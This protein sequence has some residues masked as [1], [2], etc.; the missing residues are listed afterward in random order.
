M[1]TEFLKTLLIKSPSRFLLQSQTGKGT[2]LGLSLAYDI[3]TK[4]HNGTTK[5]ESKEGEGTKFIITLPYSINNVG[6][7][8]N[9]VATF[10]NAHKTDPKMLN[11]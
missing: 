3:I 5:A 4:E 6:R 9:P 11:R 10:L 2:G 8:T 1:V 7:I